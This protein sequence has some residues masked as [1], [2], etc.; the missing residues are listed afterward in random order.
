VLLTS[1]L[2]KF[3][4]YGPTSPAKISIVELVEEMVSRLYEAPCK[5]FLHRVFPWSLSS[6]HMPSLVYN[7]VRTRDCFL[8]TGTESHVLFH[9]KH[10][11]RSGTMTVGLSLRW[12]LSEVAFPNLSTEVFSTETYRISPRIVETSLGTALY[13]GYDA[14]EDAVS[15]SISC[16]TLPLRWDYE[17]GFFHAPVGHGDT[18]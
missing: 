7:F 4:E 15:Y 5:D 6:K 13:C 14:Y 12:Q 11:Y 2:Q 18:V 1:R 3:L 17:G 9:L 8:Y 16:S 10:S